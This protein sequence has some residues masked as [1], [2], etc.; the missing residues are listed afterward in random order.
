VFLSY[1]IN[2][3]DVPAYTASSWPRIL[4]K[5][6]KHRS[7]PLSTPSFALLKPAHRTYRPFQSELDFPVFYRCINFCHIL[8]CGRRPTK[9]FTPRNELFGSF[10]VCLLFLPFFFR[11][12][13]LSRRCFAVCFSFWCW[14]HSLDKSPGRL[15]DAFLCYRRLLAGRGCAG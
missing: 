14:R 9:I 13:A 12:A 10:P 3:L 15:R 6:R 5:G 11:F 2:T 1:S 8:L 7:K 4:F